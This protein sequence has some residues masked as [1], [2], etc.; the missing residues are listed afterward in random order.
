M[1]LMHCNNCHA[2]PDDKGIPDFMKRP[3]SGGLEMEMPM[4]GTGKLYAANITSD[5]E[6]GIG[7]WTVEQV[8]ASIKSM[9]RPDGL[10]IQGPMQFYLAGWSKMEDR[11]LQAIAAYVKQIPAMTKQVPKSTFKA[12]VHMGPP[13]VLRARAR[14]LA[15]RTSDPATGAPS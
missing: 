8:A 6:T 14:R 12:T 1:T 15:R 13:P 10:L 2:T 7:K 11:D 4:L 3:F 5:P 9:T